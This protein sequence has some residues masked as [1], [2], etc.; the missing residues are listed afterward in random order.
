MCTG[1][2]AAGSSSPGASTKRRTGALLPV[3]ALRLAAASSRTPAEL[4][5]ALTVMHTTG[6]ALVLLSLIALAACRTARL[7]D[8]DLALGADLSAAQSVDLNVSPP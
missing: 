6:C 3:S 2:L 4:S 5:S 1:S 7:L 8:E